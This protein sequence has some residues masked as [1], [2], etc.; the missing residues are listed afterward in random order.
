MQIESLSLFLAVVESKSLT[1]AA[2]QCCITPQGASASIRTLEKQLDTLLFERTGGGAL[3]PTKEGLAIAR[4]AER[5][6]NAYRSLRSVAAMQKS[7]QGQWAQLKIV[8]SPFVHQSI[9]SYIEEYAYLIDPEIQTNIEILSSFEM[10]AQFENMDDDTL[11]IIDLPL[12]LKSFEQSFPSSF[13]QKAVFEEGFFQP[14]LMSSFKLICSEGSAYANR[15]FVKW[16]EIVTSRLACHNDP[17]LLAII[18]QQI[19]AIE[20][21]QPGLM[22]VDPD[23]LDTA[24]NEYGMIGLCSSLPEPL[25]MQ[26]QQ[27]INGTTIPLEPRVSHVAGVLGYSHNPRATSFFDYILRVLRQSFPSYIEENDAALFFDIN[28]QAFSNPK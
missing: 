24:V 23:I 5:V 13:I 17:F 1:K 28:R 19:G 6:V 20:A 15:E 27:A 21:I 12:H 25:R 16:A 11:C 18:G 8:V 3:E 14:F 2:K 9:S 26:C 22:T 7:E 10:A 4:E